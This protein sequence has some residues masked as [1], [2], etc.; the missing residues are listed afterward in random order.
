MTEPHGAHDQ[1]ILEKLRRFNQFRLHVWNRRPDLSEHFSGPAS[2]EYFFWLMWFGPELFPELH[3]F[4]YPTPDRTLIDRVVGENSSIHDFYTGGIQDW[5]RIE[6]GLREGGFDFQRGGSILDFGCGCARVLRFFFVYAETCRIH[7]GD[8]DRPAIEWCKNH[9]DFA[10]FEVLPE[11]PPTCYADGQF[12]AVYAFSVFSHFSEQRQFLWLEEM[13][14]ITRPG[15]VLVFTTQGNQMIDMVLK[16]A[17]PGMLAPLQQRLPQIERE[18]FAFLPYKK[19]R[20]QRDEN[21]EHFSQWNLNE[22]GDTFILKPYIETH[23]TRYFDLVAHK[24]P[25]EHGQDVVILRRRS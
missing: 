21:T 12:D 11:N 18:S 20:F 16:G 22:Y 9:I 8:V 13:Q 15:A 25:V 10:E 1:R 19:L 5:R 24:E 2:P 6:T 4:L 3:E 14:R 7:G 23:W 17:N